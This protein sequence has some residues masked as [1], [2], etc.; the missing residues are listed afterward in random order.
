MLDLR[1]RGTFHDPFMESDQI[2]G[3]S[4]LGPQV[5]IIS[6]PF[7]VFTFKWL[8]FTCM[9]KNLLIFYIL[10]FDALFSGF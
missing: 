4:Q 7:C 6:T 5:S 9:F 3:I 1:N 10:P 8:Q 2:I